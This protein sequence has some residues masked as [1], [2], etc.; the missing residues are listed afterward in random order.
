MK[1]IFALVAILFI[2]CGGGGSTASEPKEEKEPIKLK[3]INDENFT[4]QWYLAKNDEFYKTHN[5]N[6]NAHIHAGDYFGIYRGKDVK[7]AVIDN[8]L[9]VNH[10]DLKGAISSTYNV[11][12]ENED[13]SHDYNENHGTLVTGIIGARA[14]EIDIFG[15]A[16][17][18]TISFF[19][20]EYKL[21]ADQA[22]K[23]FKK[24][25]ELDPDIVNCSFGG[26]YEVSEEEKQIIKDLAKN[27]RGGKG[28][29][30]VFSS[31]NRNIMTSSEAA[32]PEVIS[33]GATNK[34]NNRSSYSNCSPYL[35]ILAPGGDGG[36]KILSLSTDNTLAKK[37]GTSFAAPIVSGVI[38]MM[39]EANPDLTRDE[40]E[41][42][43]H[44][45]ADKIPAQGYESYD[46]KGFN[47]CYGY[48]KLNAK[49][50]IEASL[51]L[52]K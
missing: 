17:E 19:K 39:L 35:D 42:I 13:V 48:G 40:V 11:R 34:D 21:Y 18:S 52:K 41:Y 24:V 37:D 30:I 43:L 36:L 23:I 8:G 2:G 20:Y 28:T 32:I 16:S 50:A 4:Q 38:A 6:K 26:T 49:K 25:K 33:V 3:S 27:G 47:R 46:S 45:T 9:D 31:G 10:P 22:T 1:Y 44:T 7:I 15:I 12:K 29:I 51:A 5:I 14:N